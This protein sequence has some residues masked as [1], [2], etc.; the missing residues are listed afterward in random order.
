[1][2]SA[3]TPVSREWVEPLRTSGQPLTVSH[4]TP[5]HVFPR[6]RACQRAFGLDTSLAGERKGG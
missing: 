2:T 5:T 4:R 3:S 6:S 1:M